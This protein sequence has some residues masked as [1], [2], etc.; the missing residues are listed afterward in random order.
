MT[1]IE[2]LEIENDN[3][4]KAMNDQLVDLQLLQESISYLSEEN[5]KMKEQLKG[6]I[7]VKTQNYMESSVE[8][9]SLDTSIT[10]GEMAM[11]SQSHKSPGES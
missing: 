2:V 6:S 10:Y 5:K 1:K 8:E 9:G 3:L 4:E 11:S 7:T